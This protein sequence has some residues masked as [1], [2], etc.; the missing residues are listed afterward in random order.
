MDFSRIES[1]LGYRIFPEGVE[2][3]PCPDFL[4]FLPEPKILRLLKGTQD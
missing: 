1:H 3:A 2:K 4:K